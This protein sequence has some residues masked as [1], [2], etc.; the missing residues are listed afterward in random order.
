MRWLPWMQLMHKGYG[1]SL[2]IGTASGASHAITA[3]GFD[4]TLVGGKSN[5][6]AVY[7]TDSDDRVTAL[8]KW[9]WLIL[10]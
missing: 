8:K 5:Y 3:W 1:I 6:T 10:L 2:V 9:A 7:I 4:Y